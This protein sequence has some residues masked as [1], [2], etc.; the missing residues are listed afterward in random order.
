MRID[1]VFSGAPG[2]LLTASCCFSRT[3]R[4]ATLVRRGCS[5]HAP[6]LVSLEVARRP[7]RKALPIPLWV[8]QSAAFIE[9][10]GKLQKEAPL[11]AADADVYAGPDL[12]PISS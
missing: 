12:L 2:W 3:L 1:G 4:D 7:P 8:C 10:I 9:I 11:L 6:L 5:D